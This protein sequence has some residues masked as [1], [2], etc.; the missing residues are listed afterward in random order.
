M[1]AGVKTYAD[2]EAASFAGMNL[3]VVGGSAI[4]AIAAELLGSA[5]SEGAFTTAT[6]IGAGEFLIKSY[7]RSGKT[8][9]LVAG[10]NAADTEKAAKVLLNEVINTAV[11]KEYKGVSST[12]AITVIA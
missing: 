1:S 11:G 9:L 7:D 2:T 8:A 6:G 12:E 3:V 4:N 5:Y 10:Y